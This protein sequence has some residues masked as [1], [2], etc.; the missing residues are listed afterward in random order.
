[1]KQIWSGS[2]LF[3]GI[4]QTGCPYLLDYYLLSFGGKE[5]KTLVWH[6]N[7][8]LIEREACEGVAELETGCHYSGN[9]TIFSDD[10]EGEVYRFSN[11]EKLY[12]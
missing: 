4:D 9:L 3:F 1:M 2:E 6:T 8:G 12:L 5:A 10:E 7:Y 11:V